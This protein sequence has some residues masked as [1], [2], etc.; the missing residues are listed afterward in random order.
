[1]PTYQP[2]MTPQL[3]KYSPQLATLVFS[4]YPILST[5]EEILTTKNQI[6]TYVVVQCQVIILHSRLEKVVDFS[7]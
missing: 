2:G 7:E 1:M 5:Y 4:L 3:F 6:K